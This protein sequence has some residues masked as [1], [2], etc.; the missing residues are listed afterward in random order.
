[1]IYGVARRDALVAT[2]GFPDVLGPDHV[3]L[4]RL[5]LQGPI[6][7]VGGHLY[8][9][10]QNRPPESKEE[11][12]RRAWA[13]LHP[14]MTNAVADAPAS[15][16]YRDLR[17]LHIRA[18]RESNLSFVEKLDGTLATLACFRRRF[19]VGSVLVTLLSG[20]ARITRLRTRLYRRLGA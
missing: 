13:D 20:V 6:L 16:L 2:G 18:V 12:R 9:R 11:H 3:V 14:A 5:A 4:A 7:R 8:L 17:D 15:R 19:G 1:M 10:R